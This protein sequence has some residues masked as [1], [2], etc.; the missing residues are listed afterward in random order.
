MARDRVE[1]ADRVRL[2]G[3]I[4]LPLRVDEAE[5]DR[6]LVVGVGQALPQRVARTARLGLR[7]HRDRRARRARWNAIET[8][9]ARHL[10][11]QV[12]LDLDVEA[13]RGRRDD[14]GVAFAGMREAEPAENVG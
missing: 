1:N 9:D 10:L 12:L 8:V 7:A 11:D 5:V 13:K 14:E 4:G 2:A 6:F 3:E